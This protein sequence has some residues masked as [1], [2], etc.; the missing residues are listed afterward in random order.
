MCFN[1]SKA[2]E[3]VRE[4]FRN[5]VLVIDRPLFVGIFGGLCCVLLDID[6]PIAYAFNIEYA[7]F[8]HPVY[9]VIAGG[10]IC[11]SIAFVGGLLLKEILRR[12][13]A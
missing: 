9:F 12:K 13:C 5:M 6:H 2:I 7:R 3:M 1:R 8:L 11:G 10:I 4:T